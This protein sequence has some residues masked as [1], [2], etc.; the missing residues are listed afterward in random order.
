[1]DS[2]GGAE[3]QCD[4]LA[5]GLQRKHHDVLYL[6]PSGS[7]GRQYEC[8]YEVKP[9]ADK[10]ADIV[11]AV[12]K[13]KPDVIYWRAYKNNFYEVV[14]ILNRKYPVLYAV[15]AVHDFDWRPSLTKGDL[16]RPRH[17]LRTLRR[18]AMTLKQVLGYQYVSGLTTL[19]ED[20]L[21]MLPRM[22]KFYIPNSM[23]CDVAEFAW[24]R[25]YVVW[26]ANLKETKNPALFVRLANE[27]A[28]IGVDFLMIGRFCSEYPDLKW[29]MD[30]SKT[31]DNFFY[32]G[33]LPPSTVNGAL[34]LSICHIHTCNP[35]G[36][37][38]I[39]IQAWLMGKTSISLYFDPGGFLEKN[40][41]GLFAAGDWHRFVGLVRSAID[42]HD[43]RG[44]LEYQAGQFARE[45]FSVE[46][47]VNKLEDCLNM[48]VK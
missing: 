28:G 47:M 20:Y 34:S 35:E 16:L 44:K 45:S 38:N 12:E 37:G 11:D 3:I 6:T 40:G 21:P 8:V 4:I 5:E 43:L 24:P 17:V 33:E 36:F 48:F 10:A 46:R 7:V 23:R 32:L 1:M 25:P 15:S 2:L 30:S 27:L 26:V 19:N 29:I 18:S 31:P 9:V 14:K 39:F 41:V 42:D 13:F 22:P